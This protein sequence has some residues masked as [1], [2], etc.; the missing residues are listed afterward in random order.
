MAIATTTR[1]ATQIPIDA[2]DKGAPTIGNNA[3]KANAAALMTPA[4]LVMNWTNMSSTS[5]RHPAPLSDPGWYLVV[6]GHGHLTG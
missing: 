4:W 3:E 6:A 5:P 1:I 2:G